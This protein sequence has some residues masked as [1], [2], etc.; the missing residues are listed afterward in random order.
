MQMGADV[1][2]CVQRETEADS[3][4][5]PLFTLEHGSETEPPLK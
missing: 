2:M 3:M 4:V 5:K 1:G